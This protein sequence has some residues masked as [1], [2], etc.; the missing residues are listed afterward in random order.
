MSQYHNDSLL[1]VK[2]FL[3][4]KKLPQK[5]M[6]KDIVKWKYKVSVVIS[7]IVHDTNDISRYKLGLQID[8]LDRDHSCTTEETQHQNQ[9]LSTE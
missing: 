7:P 3:L 6:Q 1:E 4:P 9:V 8:S 2:T 5:L